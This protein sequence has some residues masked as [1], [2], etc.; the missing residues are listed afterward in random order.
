[1]IF[2]EIYSAYYQ[3]VSHILSEALKSPVSA[4]Q[5]REISEKYAFSESALSIETAFREQRWQLILP[6]GTTPLKHIPNIPVTNLEKRWLKAI[7]LDRRIK[8]F[9]CNFGLPDNIEPLFTE[10]DF[11]IYDNYRDGD[12]FENEEYIRNFRLILSSIRER[13]PLDITIINK[14][15][16]NVSFTVMPDK[17]EY[18]EKDDKF[19]LL[20]SGCRTASVINLGKIVSCELHNGKFSVE[21]SCEHIG[22][23][24]TLTLEL[25]DE[26]NALERVMLHFS[27]FEKTAQQ[28]DEKHY[29]LTI[30]YDQ[31]DETEMLI[32]VLSFGQMVRVIEPQRFV[33]MIKNRLKRQKSCGL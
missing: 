7:S 19:R 6:N 4:E 18:S 26:R 23:K 22:R 3:A 15:Q 25:V 8:L 14:K 16:N 29:R 2:S 32:R 24:R 21:K 13:K 28:L 30:K 9:D 10:N 20:T 1:M 27:H 31:S 5:I 11:Y 12:D 17:L 33:N